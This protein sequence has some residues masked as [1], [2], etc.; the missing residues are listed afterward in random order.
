MA[1]R[2]IELGA[3]VNNEDAIGQTALFYSAREGHKD[4][5]ELLINKGALVDKYDK[6][7][8][9]PY[10]LARKNNRIAVMEL[11]VKYGATPVKDL[12]DGRIKPGRKPGNKRKPTDQYESKKYILMGYHEGVWKQLEGASLQN[13]LA[14]STEVAKYLRNPEQLQNLNIPTI[15]PT[16]LQ[17]HWDKA[18]KKILAHLWRQVG[19]AHFHDPVDAVALKI[20][21]Y[22]E[23]IKRPMDLGTIKTKL[24]TCEYGS[25]KEF[26][27]DVELVFDNCVA[28]NEED[29]DYGMLAI[30]LKE[31]FRK[32]C[33]LYSLDYYMLK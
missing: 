25:C 1:K 7:Q 8:Q 31:E 16:N 12:P 11:L 23:V 3:D 14:S 27:D 18:A 21:D 19:A 26:V 4:L 24:T 15:P 32:Q 13:F 30:R 17:D 10:H 6:K 33:Q 20:P 28:Y 2:L 9:T 5:C 29:S 22:Y